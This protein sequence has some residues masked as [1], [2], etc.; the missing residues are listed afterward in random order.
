MKDIG[1]IRADFPILSQKVHGKPLI[2][3]DNAATTQLP[4]C[5]IDRW[6][7]HYTCGNG[8]VRRGI[9]LLAEQST[10][11]MERVRAHI[12][13]FLHAQDQGEMIFTSGATDSANLV[14]QSFLAGRLGEGDVVLATDLEHHSNY[15]VWQQL[16]AACG[17]SFRTIP[18]VDG[19]LDMD[20]AVRL[21]DEKVKLLAVTAVSNVFGTVVDVD[22]LCAMAHKRDIPVYVDA[23]QAL[24]HMP[25]D[26]TLQPWDFVG[27]SAHKLLGPTGVGCL[28]VRDRWLAQ[29]RP[30]RCGGGMVDH[31]TR[32]HTTFAKL[33]ER[34][35]AGTP[36]YSGIIA[37][38]A[39]ISYLEELGIAEIAA[40]EQQLAAELEKGLAGLEHVCVLGHPKRRAGLVSVTVEHAH[41][42][43]IARILDQYG[44]AVRSGSLC[45][46]PAVRSMGAQAV[47]RYSPALY[48]TK[49]EIAGAVTYTEQ[50]IRFLLQ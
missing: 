9:H 29:M 24:R 39:A 40:Y 36:N 47:V 19:E 42:Y 37:W 22:A 28:F 20:A 17:A 30:Y 43:D 35:E 6:V 5:V 33:P 44:V 15:V 25:V 10:T 31:V 2:Y 13:D 18:V 21:M 32:E 3:L 38:D 4:Q 27:F 16:C 26:L 48:N 11:K 46:Q 45:A 14:A 50:A 1:R 12:K 7:M 41:P 49:E 34:L 23:A 8:N